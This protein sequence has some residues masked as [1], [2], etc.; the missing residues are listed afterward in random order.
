MRHVLATVL[1]SSVLFLAGCRKDEPAAQSAPT[2][3]GAVEAVV[4]DSNQ[5]FTPP[6]IRRSSSAADTASPVAAPVPDST[7]PVAPA[8][9]TPAPEAVKSAV[10][11]PAAPSAPV[12]APSPKTV[13]VTPPADAPVPGETGDWVV[14]VGIHKSEEGANAMVAKLGA[15][16]IPAYVVQAASGAGLSG[17]YWRVRVGRFVARSDAQKYGDMVLKPAGQSFWVDRKANE[18]PAA[19]GTP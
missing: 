13:S 8:A 17:S 7:A 1:A 3:S 6:E 2:D 11:A 16:G 12:P 18:A 19:G 9:P 15:K 14:Q 10:P 5:P 4:P